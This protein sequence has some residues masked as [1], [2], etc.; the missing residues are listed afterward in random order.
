MFSVT[1]ALVVFGLVM[2]YSSSAIFASQ[3]YNNSWYFFQKQILWAL[4]GF[5]GLFMLMKTDYHFLQN[6]SRVLIIISFILLAL[7]LTGVFGREV[8]GAKRWIS[9]LSLIC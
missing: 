7:V 5:A 3:Q 9:V 1:V 8:G 4:V 2:I 6:Y